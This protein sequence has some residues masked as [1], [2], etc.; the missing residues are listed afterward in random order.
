MVDTT[1]T[2]TADPASVA[3]RLVRTFRAAVSR[4]V[5]GSLT[6]ATTRADPD[7]DFGRASRGEGPLWQVISERPAHL[8]GSKHTSW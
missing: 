6:A 4:Q 1:W 8:L 7:F 2:G 5:Y 3:Y